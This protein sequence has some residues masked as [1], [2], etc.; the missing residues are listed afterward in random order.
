ML[1]DDMEDIVEVL[2]DALVG[3]AGWVVLSS[4]RCR[5]NESEQFLARFSLTLPQ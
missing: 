1:S 3:G 4:W 5:Q 2:W